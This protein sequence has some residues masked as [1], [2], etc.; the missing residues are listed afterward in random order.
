M[1]LSLALVLAGD[2]SVST[3]LLVMISS[4]SSSR[5]DGGDNTRSGLPGVDDIHDCDPLQPLP[6]EFSIKDGRVKGGNTVGSEVV[7][8]AVVLV[9][10]T[11][12][13][14]EQTLG[15]SVSRASVTI[16]GGR[17]TSSATLIDE[18]DHEFSHRLGARRLM[19]D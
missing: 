7:T 5:E 14:C 6:G 9:G 17:G 15:R 11:A 18:I 4:S 12:E 1:R 10:M 13:V 2:I 8:E 16:N 3:K 19:G